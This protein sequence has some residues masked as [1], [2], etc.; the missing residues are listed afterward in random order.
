MF[1]HVFLKIILFPEFG[2]F[3][4]WKCNFGVG[5]YELATS[6]PCAE[7]VKLYLP[8]S[9]CYCLVPFKCKEPPSQICIWAWSEEEAHTVGTH[10]THPSKRSICGGPVVWPYQ[11]RRPE[12]PQHQRTQNQACFAYPVVRI[13]PSMARAPLHV[14]L[15]QSSLHSVSASQPW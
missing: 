11:R 7:F 15:R 1:A 12:Q 10:S 2:D 4:S 14:N 3:C 8:C 13:E 5:M 6:G 9:H